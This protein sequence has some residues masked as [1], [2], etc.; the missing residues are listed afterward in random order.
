MSRSGKE[1]GNRV[2]NKKHSL[3]F[4]LSVPRRVF[5]DMVNLLLDDFWLIFFLPLLGLL[6]LNLTISSSMQKT[7]R[8]RD[9]CFVAIFHCIGFRFIQYFLQV[10]HVSAFEIFARSFF[11]YSVRYFILEFFYSVPYILF[12]PRVKYGEETASNCQ[13]CVL[14]VR[15]LVELLS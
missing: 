8:R 7:G 4:V 1:C 6:H 13:I 10:W 3:F 9:E 14:C 11:F 15:N 12:S 5:F 2:D